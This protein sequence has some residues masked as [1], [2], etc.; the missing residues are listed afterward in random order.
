LTD[1]VVIGGGAAGMLAATG[2]RA[3]LRERGI[4]DRQFRIAVLERNSRPGE[5]IRISGGGRCNVT[6][7]G[8]PAELLK[9][10]FLRKREQRFLRHAFHG[11]TSHD[12]RMMLERQGVKSVA[13]QDG[14]VFPLSGSSFDVLSALT[15]E[16]HRSS[17]EF[18]PARRVLEVS[19]RDGVFC[20]GAGDEKMQASRLVIAT[21]GVSYSHT[22]TTGDGFFMAER[23]GHSV[24]PSSP[25]LAPV[26][27]DPAP[28]NLLAGVALRDIV[29]YVTNKR[30]KAVRRGDVLFTHKGL[31]GPACLS[32]SR[33]IAGML[34][35][36][37]EVDLCIDL[38]PDICHAD[39]E[40]MLHECSKLDGA[41]LVR[42][43]LRRQPSIPA[44]LTAQVM[45]QAGVPADRQWGHLARKERL[46]L[47][48]T[49]KGFLPGKV[50]SVPLD[51]GEISA[52]GIR[53]EDVNAV[54]MESRICKGLFFA[55][56]ILDY[57]GEIGGFN[58]QAA[59][60]T[61]WLAGRSAAAAGMC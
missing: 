37:G 19:C 22:G 11:F 6:H 20:I 27:L 15:R 40:R 12:I 5:K 50:V 4:A 41:G 9:K 2:A 1:L 30:G 13:R 42:S 58:L 35:N 8:T 3:C 59:F 7:D 48:N 18:F 16:L 21:G 45:K 44:S 47:Q 54:T 34:D 61:G 33:D 55:G 31:T 23:L 32:L 14:K 28:G 38:L 10:G 29:L 52:G 60:S 49:L 36:C 24:I 26:R 39:L 25:A 46:S 57:C 43:F 51:A 17:V 53:L 56:E